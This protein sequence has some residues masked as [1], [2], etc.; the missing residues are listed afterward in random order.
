[1][2]PVR[3][4]PSLAVR[5]SA[6][7]I[8]AQP[9]GCSAGAA[10][11]PTA[12]GP[13]ADDEPLE[14]IMSSQP[15]AAH[16][17]LSRFEQVHTLDVDQARHAVA[18][19]FCPHRLTALDHA[20]QFETRFH[21]ARSGQV[22]LSYL[23]YGGEVRIAPSEQESF[24]LVLIPLAGQAELSY[25]REQVRYNSSGC[26]GQALGAVAA[27]AGPIRQADASRRQN[28]PRK[29]TSRRSITV[30]LRS[31]SCPAGRYLSPPTREKGSSG[32]RRPRT[33]QQAD[34][35]SK[36]RSAGQNGPRKTTSR[37]S[38]TVRLSS[39]SCPAG[40]YRVPRPGRRAVVAMEGREPLSRRMWGRRPGRPG[41]CLL[42]LY[43]TP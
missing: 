14:V 36:T 12:T 4:Q 16:L 1:M 41:E 9:T 28:G 13:L 15:S 24:Y 8:F 30:R 19:A 2:T 25:G 18:E 38:I 6:Y 26:A 29:T 20:R 23:D 27:P 40:R 5:G 3:Q 7:G 31:K 22:S 17:P 21:S 32:H 42:P 43:L 37:R 39:K 33:S 35:G 34:V 10:S 11:R